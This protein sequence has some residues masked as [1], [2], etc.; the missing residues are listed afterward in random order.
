[1]SDRAREIRQKQESVSSMTRTEKTPMTRTEWKTFLQLTANGAKRADA[2]RE[3]KVTRQTF[4]AYLIADKNAVEQMRQA[5]QSWGRRKWPV[6]L[7]EDVLV[8]MAVGKT[9]DEAF[10]AE[11]I[12]DPADRAALYRLFLNDP[13]IRRMYDEARELQAENWADKMIHIS[14]QNENDTY[15]VTSKGG[16][17]YT[18]TNH[19]VVNRSVL[20]VKTLQW[21]IGR[22]HHTRF[23]DRVKQDIEQKVE[24]NHA[25]KLTRARQRREKAFKEGKKIRRKLEDSAAKTNGGIPPTQH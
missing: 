16:N 1:M 2:L 18:R 15:E 5:E 23:G 17:T 3:L 8:H 9:L 14:N 22:T 12:D 13:G 7:I 10:S 6:E 24:V 19:E 20:K 11:F 4:E 21:V 25:D